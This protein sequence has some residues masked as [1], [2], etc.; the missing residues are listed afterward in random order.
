MVIKPLWQLRAGP[1]MSS[2]VAVQDMTCFCQCAHSHG[3]RWQ[4]FYVASDRAE[5]SMVKTPDFQK[6][7]AW[8]GRAR[9]R[10]TAGNDRAGAR[11]TAGPRHLE[12]GACSR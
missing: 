6:C 5:L 9:I 7:T 4:T 1:Q 3:G 11:F 8:C 2:H 12:M 10:P